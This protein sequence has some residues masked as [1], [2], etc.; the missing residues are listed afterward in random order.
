VCRLGASWARQH[1]LEAHKGAKVTVYAIWMPM[2][3]GD[4]RSEWDANVLD[5]PRVVNLWD[6]HR[7]AGL[8]FA[9]HGTGGL[10]DPSFPVWDAY[11]AFSGSAKW[12]A[13]PAPLIAAGSS[14][15]DNVS[16]LERGF[17]PLLA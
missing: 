1:I 8:W 10:G 2:L 13:E 4:A 17:M 6:A 14:I 9:E 16:G 7:F 15:I 3:A 5:D 11:F 12:D